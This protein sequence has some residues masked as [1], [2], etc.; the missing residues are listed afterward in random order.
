[1][2]CAQIELNDGFV[3]PLRSTATDRTVDVLRPY[4]VFGILAPFNF[5][6]ALAVNMTVAA[7]VTGNTAVLKPSDKTPRSTAFAARLLAESLPAGV[8][9]LVH[10]GATTGQ[11]VVES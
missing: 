5:P 8:L 4:G 9:N 7:L 2:Y 10:G 1:H 11:L 3:T 6:V